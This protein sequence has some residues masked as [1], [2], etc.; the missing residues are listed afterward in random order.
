MNIKIDNLEIESSDCEKLLGI[1]I[2]S[3]LK[4]K[5]HLD[6]VFKTASRKVNALVSYYTLH[7]YC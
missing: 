4:F 1:K 5:D 7:E 2:D 6:G 3:K